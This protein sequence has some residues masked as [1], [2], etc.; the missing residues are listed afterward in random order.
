MTMM[1]TL[2][3]VCTLQAKNGN[4]WQ[5]GRCPFSYLAPCFAS[6]YIEGGGCVHK[7]KESMA[8]ENIFCNNNLFETCGL[9]K[10]CIWRVS[11]FKAEVGFLARA[12]MMN[13]RKSKLLIAPTISTK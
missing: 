4:Q 1:T 12:R 7:R 8:Y 2:E 11:V 3:V 13:K 5:C 6:Q 9:I 10:S